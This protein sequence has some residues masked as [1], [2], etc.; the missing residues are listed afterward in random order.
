MRERYVFL[1]V[2]D[3]DKHSMTLVECAAAGI[4]T[5]STNGIA[6]QQQRAESESLGHAVVERALACTHLR[7]LL[8][9]TLNLG[10]NV[11]ACGSVSEHLCDLAQG[12]GGN[13][14]AL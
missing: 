2:F 9:Q 4:L 3:V 8:Q 1:L 12:F 11:E 5:A 13:S 14:S 10:M 7:A 6:F